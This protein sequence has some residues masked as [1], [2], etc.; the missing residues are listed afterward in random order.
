MQ[1]NGQKE[2]KVSKRKGVIRTVN[3]RK[4]SRPGMPTSSRTRSI[5]PPNPKDD[6]EP[7]EDRRDEET[8]EIA[9]PPGETQAPL[10]PDSEIEVVEAKAIVNDHMAAQY[11]GLSLSRDQKGEKLCSLE[12]SLQL[13]DD[14][15]DYVPEKAATAYTWLLLTDNKESKLNHVPSQTVDIFEE[16]KAKKPMLH[17]VGAAVEKASVTMIEESGKGKSRKVVRFVFRL[18]VERDEKTIDFAAWNDEREFWI[19][20]KQTQK[21]FA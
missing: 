17:I 3:G 21:S 11:M 16:P 18:K 14:H 12:F 1:G 13:T 7:P 2:G 5:E 4:A 6:Q 10:I 15:A 19:D 20:M 9:D 8:E